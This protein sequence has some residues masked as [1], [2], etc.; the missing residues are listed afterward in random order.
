MKVADPDGF[1]NPS[2]FDRSNADVF[3][4]PSEDF[5]QIGPDASAYMDVGEYEPTF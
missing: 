1:Y 2:S 4:E 5:A 3:Y